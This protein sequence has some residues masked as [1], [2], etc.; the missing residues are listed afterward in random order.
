MMLQFFRRFGGAPR[1]SHAQE[2]TSSA[3]LEFESPTAALLAAPI[4][5]A[6]RS[7]TWIV[8][9]MLPVFISALGFFPVDVVVTAP[10]RVV[11]LQPT[12]VVQPLETSIVRAINVREGQIVHSGDVL[13]RLDSTF[14]GADVGTLQAQSRSFQAEV[15]RLEAEASSTLYRPTTSDA[16]AAVQ[17]AI[18]G[19]RQAQHR[20][21]MESYIQKISALEVQ[22][23]QANV[24]VQ[25]FKERLQ[26]A[27]DIESK[28]LQLE[29]MQVGSQMSRMAAQ[30]DRIEMRRKLD[31]ATTMAQR[32][33]RDLRQMTAER[34]AFEQQWKTQINQELHE[35]RRSLSD[36]KEA[37]TKAT[38]RHQLVDLRAERDS[39]VLTV[40]KVSVGSVMQSGDQF[41]TLVP[42]DGALEIEARV[43]GSDAGFA[44]Q[45]E[46]VVIKFDTFPYVHYGSAEGSVRTVS[47][48]SFNSTGEEMRRST[49]LDL[50]AQTATYYK[51]RIAVESLNMHDVPGGFQLKPGMP[52][53]ADIM[54]GKRTALAYIMERVLPVGLEGMREP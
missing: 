50:G 21:Q 4:Q 34:D 44:H 3:I 37:L 43:D 24:D 2:L 41:I 14:A 23:I 16:G 5:P 10:G 17:A 33:S 47:A 32:A 11:S 29:R 52:V 40:A 8:V 31:S 46:R 25:A 27:A 18:Y 1:T 39:V 7:I 38:L 12:V 51:A 42:T 9:S 15:D 13:A 28:R 35:R 22:L 53:M 19:E 20:F 36:A 45:G 48:D 6:A 30:D 54:V 26:L 49:G